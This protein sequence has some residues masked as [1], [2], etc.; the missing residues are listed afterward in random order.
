MKVFL[1]FPGFLCYVIGMIKI[2]KIKTPEW[3]IRR[4]ATVN[5]KLDKEML[6]SVAKIQKNWLQKNVKK[7]EKT[8]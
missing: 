1:D 8:S 4:L 2:M 7:S 3:S 5:G 6:A